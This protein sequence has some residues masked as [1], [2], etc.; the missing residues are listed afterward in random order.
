MHAP[1]SD[2]YT[3]LQLVKRSSH[4]NVHLGPVPDPNHLQHMWI[5]IST[6]ESVICTGEEGLGMRLAYTSV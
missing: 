2:H 6:E 1:A 4:Y 5:A 3:Q